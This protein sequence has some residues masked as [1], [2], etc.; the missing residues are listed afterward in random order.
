[1]DEKEYLE[2]VG[3]PPQDDDLERVNCKNA[4]KLGHQ[5][6]GFCDVHNKPRFICGCKIVVEEDNEP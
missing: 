2:K 6:C 4:G 1:M 5:H 3:C